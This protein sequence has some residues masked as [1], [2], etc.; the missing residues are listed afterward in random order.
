M[1]FGKYTEIFVTD[2]GSLVLRTQT[3]QSSFYFAHPVV[4][5]HN[6]TCI[7]C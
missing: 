3:N 1:Q 4:V 2:V 5:S 7:E 6:S